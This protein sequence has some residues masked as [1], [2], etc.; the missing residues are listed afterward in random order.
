MLLLGKVEF[1]EP[2]VDVADP[3]LEDDVAVPVLLAEDEAREVDEEKEVVVAAEEDGT[4]KASLSAPAVMMIGTGEAEYSGELLSVTV[5]IGVPLSVPPS[6]V[7]PHTIGMVV[8]VIWQCT[9]YEAGPSSSSSPSSSPLSL[10]HVPLESAVVVVVLLSP[11]R[12]M[13]RS[14]IPVEALG[15]GVICAHW[16]TVTVASTMSHSSAGVSV[17]HCR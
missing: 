3:A 1:D 9:L 5:V 17:V 11:R 13:V 12:L 15:G 7:M 10:S 14:K 2:P 16:P 4:S 6:V 8:D